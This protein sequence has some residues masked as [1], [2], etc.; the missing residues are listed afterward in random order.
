MISKEE[1]QKLAELSRIELREGE[2]EALQKD[3][4]NILDYVGQISALEGNVV[5]DIAAN[6]NVM[7]DDVAYTKDSP[8][9]SAREAIVAAFPE[10]KNGYNV[11]RKII[12]KDE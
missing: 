5:N 1:I 3:I 4:S 2:V 6:H 12:Q 7:R 10:E 9:Y 8:L 11:V